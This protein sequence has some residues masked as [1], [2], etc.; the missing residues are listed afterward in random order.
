MKRFAIQAKIA[1]VVGN[2]LP[3]FRAR[4]LWA[5]SPGIATIEGRWLIDGAA[6]SDASGSSMELAGTK[7]WANGATVPILSAST[8]ELNILCPDSLPGSDIQ[9]VVQTGHGV[10]APVRTTARSATPG[11][12]SLDGSGKGQG[13]VLRESTD[14]NSVAMVRNY[15]VSGQPAISGERLLVYATGVGRLTNISVQIGEYKIP[16]AAINPVPNHPGLYQ[17]VVSVP[18]TVMQT[19]DLPMSL[20][21]DSLEGSI[22]TNTISIA[23]EATTW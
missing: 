20:S 11:I 2:C 19:D 6:V 12:F 23:L 9:L 14:A 13:W 22:S 21:G 7:V 4:F 3:A 18:S 10:A 5:G 15:R 8:T 16:A 17:I 1:L